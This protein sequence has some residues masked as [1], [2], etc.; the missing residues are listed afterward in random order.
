LIRGSFPRWGGLL[1]NPNDPNEEFPQYFLFESRFREFA[2]VLMRALARSTY[3]NSIMR[4]IRD[5]GQLLDSIRGNSDPEDSDILLEGT[6][7]YQGNYSH[8]SLEKS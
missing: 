8:N 4:N 2:V 1:V 6:Y 3:P 7:S 5:P